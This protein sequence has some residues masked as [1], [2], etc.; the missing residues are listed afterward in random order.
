MKVSD[1]IAEYL[2][3]NGITRVFSVTGGFAMHLNDSFGEKLNLT[4]QHGENPCGYSAVG[5]SKMN[6]EPSVVC[7]TAGCGATNAITPCLVAYQDSVPV[8]FISG[9]VPRN[10]NIRWLREK[11]GK[12][13]RVYSGSD[14]DIIDCVKHIT[15]YSHE[16]WDP[17]DLP[18]VLDECIKNLVTGRTGPVWLSI[19]LNIQPMEISCPIHHYIPVDTSYSFEFPYSEWENSLRPVILVGNGIRTSGCTE[20]F[21]K[22]IEKHKL[23]VVCSFFGTDISPAHHIG[24]VGIIGDRAG[25][26]TIQ[27]ADFILSLG[28]RISKAIV[29]Y[30]PDWFAREA[31]VI[32]VNIEQSDFGK[33]LQMNLKDF[34]K[35]DIPVKSVDDWRDKTKNWKT[36]WFRELPNSSDPR[37]PYTFLNKFF[38]EKP[39]NSICVG[40]SGSIICVAWHQALLKRGDRFIMSSHGDMGFEIP[41]GIGC[42][43]QSNKQV[44]VIVGDGAFQ[45]NLQ[46][47]QTIQTYNLQVKIL[48]FDNGGYGAIQITQDTNFKRRFGTDVKTPNIRKICYA[49]GM[50]YFMAHEL[51]AMLEYKGPCLIDVPC[52]LQQRYP[53][54]SNQMKPDGTFD[55]R[56]LEDMWPF[57]DREQFCANMCIKQIPA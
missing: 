20:L 3:L 6:Q 39:G 29:G 36:M 14:C 32:S 31:K 47:L 55:N 43:I 19:P 51:D 4:Y 45:L 9:A 10:E 30:R 17:L 35:H 12:S 23:P 22:F 50:K 24:R 13:T 57:L 54:L 26:F 5:F 25:N 18:R 42:A 52:R 41:C 49:Y 48:Y 38:N 44:Y 8:F 53:R 16:L 1:Y 56:P 28:C 15:K 40:S 33:T 34:F 37:C 21:E 7:V 46:E 2:K 27:N 11:E